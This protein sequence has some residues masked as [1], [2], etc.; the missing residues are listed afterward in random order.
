MSNPES[1]KPPPWYEDIDRVTVAT[2]TWLY[3]DPVRL[4]VRIIGLDFDYWYGRGEAD[5]DLGDDERPEPMGPDG[6]LYCVHLAS[7]RGPGYPTIIQAKG[8]A[9]SL[10]QTEIIWE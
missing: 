2:G 1:A 4:P 10:I 9:Q 7:L 8:H 3:D 5:G 6:L